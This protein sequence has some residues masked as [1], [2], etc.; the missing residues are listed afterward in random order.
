[1]YYTRLSD[2]DV[3]ISEF[4][5]SPTNPNAGNPN[6]E[7][8]LAIIEHSQFANHNGGMLAFGPDGLLY[9][10]VGDGGSANDPN[11]NA[12]NPI[13]LLGKVIRLD[14]DA[15]VPSTEIYALGLRNP[16]RFSFDRAD[17]RLSSATWA[18]VRSRRST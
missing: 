9:A 4:R 8:I 5:V 17:G 11:N 12:Q 13:T 16:W 7:R 3:V 1:M 6:S 10:G 14:V 2:G 18:K 15:A